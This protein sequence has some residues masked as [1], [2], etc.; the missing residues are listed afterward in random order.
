MSGSAAYALFQVLALLVAFALRRPSP[1]PP[2][3]RAAVVAGALFGAGLG[4]KLPFVLLSGEP[5][6]SLGPWIRDGKTILAGM[7]GGYLGVELFKALAG[8]RAKTG[9]SFA[10]PLAAAVAVGRLG[11]LFNGCCSA[12]G[13]YVPLWESAFHG[14]MAVVLWRL[15]RAGR[16]RLQ[17]LKLYL[18]AYAAFR[19]LVEFVRTEPRVWLGLTAYQYGAAALAALMAVFWALDERLKG[20]EPAGRGRV[21]S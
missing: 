8:V 6:L 18:L 20:T 19:F 14:T 9:D 4:A 7:A 5:L 13:L 12:P 1:L 3:Q 16:F 2:M 10:V 11:C 15:E 21:E 17:L